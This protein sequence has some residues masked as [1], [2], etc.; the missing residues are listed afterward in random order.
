M[1]SARPAELRNPFFD[2]QQAHSFR[3]GGVES[4][5]IVLNGQKK[6]TGHL[7][8]SNL[9]RCCMRVAGAVV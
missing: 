2:S 7:L 9:H 6:Q 8:N 3:L 5:P 4:S 1:H